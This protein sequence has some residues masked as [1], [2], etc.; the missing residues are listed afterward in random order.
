MA[1]KAKPSDRSWNRT[2]SPVGVNVAEALADPTA[3]PGGPGSS[4]ASNKSNAAEYA[5]V[6]SEAS[7]PPRYAPDASIT[8]MSLKLKSS[9]APAKSSTNPSPSS[10]HAQLGPT[11]SLRWMVVAGLVLKK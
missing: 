8:K 3:S 9:L 2:R 10:S 11:W 1:L 5:A 6:V 7:P 4:V